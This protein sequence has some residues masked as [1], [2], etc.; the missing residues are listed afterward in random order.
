VIAVTAVPA[1]ATAVTA[2]PALALVEAHRKTEA[3]YVRACNADCPDDDPVGTKLRDDLCDE[4]WDL[5]WD[6]SQCRPTT[7]AG[8]IALARHVSVDNPD[9]ERWPEEH[10]WRSALLGNIAAALEKIARV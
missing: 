2:D 8:V 3:A 6:L 9:C 7:I 1:A 5:V 10:E 4:T